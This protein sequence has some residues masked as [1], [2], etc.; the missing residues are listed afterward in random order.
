MPAAVPKVPSH[1]K[2]DL[3][4]T[5][6]WTCAKDIRLTSDVKIFGYIVTYVLYLKKILCCVS[7]QLAITLMSVYKAHM[8]NTIW[9]L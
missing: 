3:A 2:S 8:S 4:D 6:V 5:L 1:V 7:L 9:W